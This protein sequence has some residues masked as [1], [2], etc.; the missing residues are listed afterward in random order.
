MDFDQ[1]FERHTDDRLPRFFSPT[2]VNTELPW[3]VGMADAYSAIFDF[4]AHSSI[5]KGHLPIFEQ[6]ELPDHLS[7]MIDEGFGRGGGRGRS[8]KGRMRDDHDGDAQNQNGDDGVRKGQ[9]L[10]LDSV[11]GRFSVHAFPVKN[12]F[13]GIAGYQVM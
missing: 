8:I 11:V 7:V 2:L 3:T 4:D 10:K 5:L 6:G 1:V 9:P 13:T 12:L